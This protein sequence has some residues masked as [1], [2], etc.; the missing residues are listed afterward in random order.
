MNPITRLWRYLKALM[1]GKL[2]RWE[3]PEII[4]NEAVKEMKE[5]QG[6][7]RELAIQAITQRNNLQ[8]EVDKSTRLVAELEKKA[9]VALQGG[10]RELQNSSS[11]RRL[12]T[13]KPLKLC[14]PTLAPPMRLLKKLNRLSV[15]RRS[16]F[17]LRRPKLWSP[18]L[19]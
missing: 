6:K 14:A 17:G 10:N 18:R 19:R 13:I 1:S 4:L 16:V 3:D 5:N 15:V 8:S 7:N 9:M 2:D 12:S 11:K